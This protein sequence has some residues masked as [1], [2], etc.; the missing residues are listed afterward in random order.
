MPPNF[1]VVFEGSDK[2][3]SVVFLCLSTTRQA[4]ILRAELSYSGYKKI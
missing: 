2:F 1:K 3:F 4:S